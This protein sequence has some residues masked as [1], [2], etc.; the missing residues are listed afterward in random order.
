MF[1]CWLGNDTMLVNRT[2]PAGH[3]ETR[4]L[5]LAADGTTSSLPV[6]KDTLYDNVLVSPGGGKVMLPSTMTDTQMVRDAVVFLDSHTWKQ[7]GP[8][9]HGS[10][11]TWWQSDAEMG[12]TDQKGVKHLVSVL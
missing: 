2:L 5:R 11:V 3:F 6:S 12:Y 7:I 9:V 10:V 1:V 8:T 4:V